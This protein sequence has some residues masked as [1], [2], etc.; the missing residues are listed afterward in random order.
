MS[1]D[2]ICVGAIGGAFGVQGEVRIKSFTSDPLAIQDYGPLTTQDGSLEFEVELQRE[3]KNGFAARLSGVSTKEEAD[4]L[5]GA[6]LFV[7]RDRLP[8]LPDDE[9]YHSDL[10][11]L[12][13]FD[14]GGAPL[15]KVK[16]VHNHGATDLLE[17][18]IPGQSE[19]VL[20]PFTLE[21]VPTIDL[22]AGRIVADPPDGIL[23]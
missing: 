19:T 1:D 21:A 8:D 18:I 12:E 15:G 5:K 13:V 7:S 23:E 3:I 14:T 2:Q 4:A 9:F 20:I 22:K 17:L 16:A 6:R 11:G 10:M